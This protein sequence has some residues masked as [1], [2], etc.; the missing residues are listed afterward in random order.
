[1][2]PNPNWGQLRTPNSKFW[3]S[4]RS[5]NEE[6]YNDELEMIEENPPVPPEENALYDAC[7]NNIV[8]KI[9]H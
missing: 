8:N 2:M 1:M 3:S 5:P 7:Q 9:Y 6:D 4:L